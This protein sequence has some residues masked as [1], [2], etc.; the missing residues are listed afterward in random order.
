MDDGIVPEESVSQVNN[1]TQRTSSHVSSIFRSTHSTSSH[2]SGRSRE[3]LDLD[4]SALA[5]KMSS[6]EKRAQLERNKLELE[7]KRLDIDLDI[8]QNELQEQMDLAKNE[9]EILYDQDRECSSSSHVDIT[10]V[11]A[12]TPEQEQRIRNPLS[13]EIN[14][15]FDEC[16]TFL[17]SGKVDINGAK[18]CRVYMPSNMSANQV[19][20]KQTVKTKPSQK[21][22]EPEKMNQ[23]SH[24]TLS[25][26]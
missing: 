10:T 7:K 17:G 25:V 18:A 1:S 9:R 24:K 4:I 26:F 6:Q 20:K 2:K 19:E 22:I 16:Y 8:E 15:M 23:E 13:E 3:Q 12:R 14:K 21:S 11:D 5:I